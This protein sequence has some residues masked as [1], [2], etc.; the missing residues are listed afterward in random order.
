MFMGTDSEHIVNVPA[1]VSGALFRG[2]EADRLDRL[3][4]AAE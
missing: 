3:P 1:L 4:T 2:H